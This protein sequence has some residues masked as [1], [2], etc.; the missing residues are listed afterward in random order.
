MTT[1]VLLDRL[2]A[3][4]VRRC[5][6]PVR[7][8][9]LVGSVA[10]GLANAAS[11]IDLIGVVKDPGRGFRVR[12]DPFEH[13]GR[14]GSILYVTE[15]ALRR[16]LASLDRLYRAGGHLT[17][18]LATRGA[19]ARIVYDPEGVGAALLSLAQ[20]Y[21]PSPDTLQEMIRVCLGFLHD[22]LGSR[23]AGDNATAVLMARAAAAVAVDCFLL[24]RNERNLKPKWHL[25]RLQNAGALEVLEPYLRVLG[26]ER[27]DASA[28]TRTLE[29]TER[30][31]CAVL[32]V[33]DLR[34][35]AQ[36]ELFARP[37]PAAADSAREATP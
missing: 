16:R 28:A 34:S 2:R 20:R 14:P 6:Y 29:D 32:R 5:R 18:G 13:D 10:E 3:D 37:T 33:P 25:R 31:L 11:D 24:D 21:R 17:D 15:R 23:A 1:D 4:V 35:H 27:A 30:L 36:S 9:L 12:E 7:A 19:N 8:V 22:A 26:V